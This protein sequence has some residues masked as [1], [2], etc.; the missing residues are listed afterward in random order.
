MP[1]APLGRLILFAS[2]L[3]LPAGALLRA[4]NTA[5]A[6]TATGRESTY[7]IATQTLLLRGDA[8]VT[9]GD[10]LL[11]ADEIRYEDRTHTATA[12]GN[13]VLTRGDRRLIA[14]EGS[15]NFEND[16]LHVKQARLGRFP[17]YITGD[18]VDGTLEKLIITNATVF[19]RENAAYAPSIHADRLV[20]ERDRI[21]SGE[22]LRMGLLGGHFFSL[23]KFEHDLHSEL[24]SYLTGTV[25]Y[26]NNL[27]AFVVAGL[28]V[29]VAPG[30][31]L[32]GD[33]GLYTSRGLLIGPSGTYAVGNGGDDFA[34]GYLRSGYIHDFGNTGV[35]FVGNP[36]HDDRGYIEWRHQEQNGP[37]FTLNG[38]VNYWS[39]SDV[40]RD[41]KP[42]WFF[43]V[44][45]PDTFLEGA[46]TGTNYVFST[47]LRANPNPFF[48][49]QQRLPEV[50]FDLLP[51]PLPWGFAQ[52]LNASFAVLNENSYQN[53][54]GLN[55]TRLDAYYGL[56]RPTLVAPWLTFTPVAGGRW[57]Y[58][59][60]AVNGRDTYSRTIG[61]VG[62]DAVLH[63]S[64][65]FDYKNAVW[66]VD[67]LRHLFEP[68][69]SY[70]YAPEADKGQPYIP[71]IDRNIF[72][73]YLPPL[74]IADQRNIDQLAALNTMRLSLNNTLQTRDPKYG[75]RDLAELNFAADYDFSPAP[76]THELSDIYIEAALTPAPWLR[77]E[78]FERFTPHNIAQQELNYAI[79][80]TDQHWWSVRLAEHFLT[81]D[82]Q[83]YMLEY[84]QRINESYDVFGSWRYDANLHRFN[85]QIYG[86]SQRLGQTWNVRYAVTLTEGATR[87]GSFGFNI[88]VELIKF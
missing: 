63:S 20:Y 30:V 31:K 14:D 45:Q 38:E 70:R 3:L 7:D 10:L 21:V 59:A 56:E 27:G 74:S 82:Y 68:R 35:D 25:G 41:F 8:R 5:V 11:T 78:V 62:F 80:V 2:Q 1:S 9:Y 33:A 37:N 18:T 76:A 64:G 6:P 88:Q 12:K 42:S 28:H 26:R 40:L 67:G 66:E 60:N 49:M 17:F 48:R 53:L 15:Y 22:G 46:Y 36:I 85:E 61:E 52:R 75:S 77:M 55:S 73:T 29:P 39:D 79:A 57:T 4:A 23:P 81:S 83:E 44:Q 34:R 71:A 24:F 32:G 13:L 72:T 86:L 69:L 54:P 65:T 19:F 43:P 87:E 84:R 50:R 51:S 58:Y 47:F 16:T